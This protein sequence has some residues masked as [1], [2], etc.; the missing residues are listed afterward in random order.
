MH[1]EMA[2]EEN[3]EKYK[4]RIKEL[5]TQYSESRFELEDVKALLEEEKKQ[6]QF[7]QMV[8]DFTF[9][10]EIWVAP[11]GTMKYCSPSCY[12]LTGFTS[13]QVMASITIADLLI[14]ESDRDKFNDFLTQSI[15]QSLMNQSLEFRILTR[16]KQLRWCSMNVRGVY[17]KA[18][19]YLGIRASV[20]DIT[21]LK[22]A[23][24]SILDLSTGKEIENRAKIRFKTELDL[25]ERELVSFLLQLSQKN[26]LIA[27]A[28]NQLKLI[29]SDSAKKTKQQ[30]NELLKIIENASDSPVDWDMV[31]LQLEKLHPGFLERL[32]VRHHNLTPKEKKLCAYLKL[33]LSSKEIAGLQ[34]VTSKSVEI[35]RVRLRKKLKISHEIRLTRYLE[36]I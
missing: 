21:R 23:M 14:Y 24:G 16:H 22:K 28:T 6:R 13:N 26:E 12:D 36:Q 4:I 27:L 3:N 34:N 29:A 5:E 15:D 2:K 19:R 33:D 20:H 17:N 32:Q 7:Y 31:A 8:T 1:F 35:A 10:W 25:K 30:L 18:G 11:D 9:G